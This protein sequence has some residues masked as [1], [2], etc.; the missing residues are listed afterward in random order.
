MSGA[1]YKVYANDK[2]DFRGKLT[3]RLL[4]LLEEMEEGDIE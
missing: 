3:A 2:E 4:V 1:Y